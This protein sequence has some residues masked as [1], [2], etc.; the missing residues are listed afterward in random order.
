MSHAL[1]QLVISVVKKVEDNGEEDE[2]KNNK[3]AAPATTTIDHGKDSAIEAEVKAARERAIVPLETRI[4]SF[5]DMLAEKDVLY[6]S[7]ISYLS[8]Y[9]I[10]TSNFFIFRFLHLAHGKRNFIK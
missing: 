6:F 10:F 9:I 5:K 4:K 3:K 2:S 8:L 7:S 1:H